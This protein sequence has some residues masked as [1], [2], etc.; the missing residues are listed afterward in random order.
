MLPC[1][2]LD[3]GL[4]EVRELRK[5]LIERP[6][7]RAELEAASLETLKWRAVLYSPT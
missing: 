2:G 7:G 5:Q 3:K 1:P 4:L 6:E